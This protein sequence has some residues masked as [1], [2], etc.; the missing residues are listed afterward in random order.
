VLDADFVEKV[1]DLARAATRPSVTAVPGEDGRYF[2]LWDEKSQSY[3]PALKRRHEH[4]AVA[5]L[6]S[7]A[8]YAKNGPADGEFWYSRAGVVYRHTAR[9]AAADR[10]PRA[11]RAVL[12]L[13][14]SQAVRHLG[15]WARGAPWH[16][17]DQAVGLLRTVFRDSVEPGTLADT[18]SA[19]TWATGENGRSVI[20]QGTRSVG[21]NLEAR[22]EGRTAIPEV[23]TFDVP[24]W[25][26]G[27]PDLTNFRVRVGAV[28]EVDAPNQT[29][30][31][32]PFAGAVERAWAEAEGELERLLA[33]QAERAFGGEAH[34]PLYHGTPTA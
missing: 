1:A 14:A 31:F 10:D 15:E 32:V 22:L 24:A 20:G 33:L 30:R 18:I 4:H 2:L 29:F 11:D 27:G 25:E 23:V 7:L 16:K 17:Q 3:E 21:R 6:A 26:S 12:A 28:L 9:P 13:A 5:S 8:D 34:P 19:V